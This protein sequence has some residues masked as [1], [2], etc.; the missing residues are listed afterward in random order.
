MKFISGI[1]TAASGSTGGCTFSRGRSGAYIRGRVVPINPGSTYQ[2]VV[3]TALASLVAR[4][5]STLT[6]A[7]RSAWDSWAIATPQSGWGGQTYQMTGQ[8]AYVMMNSLRKQFYGSYINNPPTINAGTALTPPILT[9]ADVSDQSLTFSF[10]NTDEWAQDNASLLILHQARPQ[11][12]SVNYFKG[13]YRYAGILQGDGI[14]PP[15]SPQ[16]IAASFPFALGQRVHVRFRSQ[17]IDG[18]ISSVVRSSIISV[19]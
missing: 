17:A 1:L 14:T 12:P 9:K 4:W 16:T 7:Q 10:N 18:R 2:N 19:A 5:T 8:N 15:T 13:P 3:R 11:N 6:P